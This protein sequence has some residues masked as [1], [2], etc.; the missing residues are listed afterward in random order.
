MAEGK[1]KSG[2]AV[3]IIGGLIVFL[4]YLGGFFDHAELKPESVAKMAVHASG[5]TVKPAPASVDKPAPHPTQTWHYQVENDPMSGKSWR[6]A[7]LYS[8][9]TFALDFPYRGAQHATL[10]LRN[11]PRMGFDSIISIERG[12][13]QC[14]MSNGCK[15]QVRFDDGSPQRW[16]FMEPENHDSTILFLRDGKQFARKVLASKMIRIELKFFQQ[17]PAIVEF[18]TA[19]LD[20]SKIVL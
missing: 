18:R 13:L 6:F 19:G 16:S 2:A 14:G 5:G 20:R 4:M 10:T 3:W 1:R 8:D 11:H 17:P 12:Q 15:L 7:I 9:N